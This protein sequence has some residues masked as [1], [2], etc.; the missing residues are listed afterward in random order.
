MTST[1]IKM[2][3]DTERR[4]AYLQQLSFLLKLNKQLSPHFA[5]IL[6]REGQAYVCVLHVNVSYSC[7]YLRTLSCF[8]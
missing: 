4:A 5:K 2:F 3:N 6:E 7:L 1:D 8:I